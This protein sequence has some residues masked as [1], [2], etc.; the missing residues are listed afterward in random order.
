[1]TLSEL[2][3]A[4]TTHDIKLM[5]ECEEDQWYLCL[6]DA[7]DGILFEIGN[8]ATLGLAVWAAEQWCQGAG[9]KV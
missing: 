6:L 8:I 5:V 7:E 4:L 2:A 1:M 9:I 3:T